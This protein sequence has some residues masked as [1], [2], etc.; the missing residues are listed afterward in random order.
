MPASRFPGVSPRATTTWAAITWCGRAISSKTAGGFLAGGARRRARR[1]LR[2]LQVTQE[3]DGHWS[4]EH[5]AR[6]HA[7]LARH[8]DGR[9]GACR[10]C[11]SIWPARGRAST[12]QAGRDAGRWC[13]ERPR[14]S[15]RNGPVSPQ[16]R[17]EEDAGYSPFTLATEI[18]AL[19]V[20][21][22]LADAAA[23]AR[24]RVPA[25]NRRRLERAHRRWLYVTGTD[26]PAARRRRLLRARRRSRTSRCRIAARRLRADQEPA[27][28]SRST[29]RALRYVSLDALALVRFGLRAADD[30]RIV[31]T[32]KVI[33]ALLK[34]DT[35]RGPAWHRYNGDG[36]GEHAD[37]APFDGTGVGRAWPL[38]TGERAHYELAAGRTDVA[39]RLAR[40]SMRFAGDSGLL[41]EQVWDTADIPERELFFGQATARRGRS[42]GR[43]RST[44]SC[45]APSRTAGC[46][47][48]RRRP[49][50]GTSSTRWGPLRVIWRFNNKIRAIPIGTTL[51][52]E[53]LAAAVVHW[54]VDGW[55]TVHDTATRDTTLGVHLVDL[56]TAGL[57][58]ALGSISPS[59][60]R[61]PR[62][63]RASTSAS[64]SN[65]AG[66]PSAQLG[67]RKR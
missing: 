6:R 64:A 21:A 56:P 54:S 16:D 10:F 3:A 5:V 38:L 62:G 29:A 31:N 48:G 7:V 61:K 20:A 66:A 58:P 13:G 32:V 42:C 14:S 11:S 27:A 43:M 17:W 24:P 39:E 63:G 22:D 49:C 28:R 9:D 37:G 51:R 2:Y 46:S 60:G 44:S 59:T 15:S 40:R 35:P 23:N 19:L 8:P 36:Y 45:A 47:I 55:R 18:A 4:P 34:V 33:D 26:W 25:R 65:D 50:S 12:R 67:G 57:P 52:V 41:P 53:T 1:V 30:P